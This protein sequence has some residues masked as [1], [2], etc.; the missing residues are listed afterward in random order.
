[1]STLG[2]QR[3]ECQYKDKLY[4]LEFQVIEQDACAILGRESCNTLGVIKRTY[5]ITRDTTKDIL[6]EFEDLFTGLGCF[7]GVHRIQTKPEAMPV[8]HA[9]MKVPVAFKK[10]IEKE[11]KRMEEMGV[12]KKQTEPTEWVNSMV[13]IVKPNKIRICI[14]PQDLNR[15]IRRDHYP[16]KTLEE[17]V[18][19]MPRAKI[20]SVVHANQGF[21]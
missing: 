10:D 18:A 3:I 16:L 8:I 14:D 15:A 9:P 17:I 11:L 1:M 4:T 21:W 19:E 2:Q 13:T 20:F 5:D 7:P 12:I 6:S